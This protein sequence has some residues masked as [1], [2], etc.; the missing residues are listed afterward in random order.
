MTADANFNRWMKRASILFGLIFGYIVFADVSIPMTPHASVQRPV[1]AVAPRVAGEVTHVA[2]INNQAVA[3]GDL[4]FTV[5]ASD[6]EL[7]VEK[8][9][10]VVQEASQANDTLSAELAQA[11]AAITEAQIN[12]REMQ[13]EHQRLVSL[14]KKNLV[15]DQ[16]V[17]QMATRVEAAQAQLQAARES[18][19]TVQVKLGKAG[20]DNL[21]LRVARNQ[22]KQAELALSRTQV[23]AP[24]AGI[25]SNLQL[26]RGI[27]AQANQPLLSL[28][29]RD[30]ERIAADFREKSLAHIGQ[31]APALV[32]FDA[33]PG[34]VFHGHLDSRDYGVA[35]GQLLAD[36]QLAQP[37][38]SDRWVRDAQRVRV[39]V[40]VDESAL[41]DSLVTGARATVMLESGES[42][43]YSGLAWLQM[44]IV[45]LL[46]YVY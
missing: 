6:Y 37:D 38:D 36:G 45:S 9:R 15:S 2:V 29:A 25:V 46:H 33:L 43:W 13:R 41:P 19:H 20:E 30:N 27:Q 8:A 18:R 16:Q 10:L 3:K 42:G 44:K 14:A 39:Y 28:V 35:Q 23:V 5:D 4:L 32:V 26:T 7:A 40:S 21:R 17:D 22:L 34:S 24:A 31:H 1:I 12:Q 11:E